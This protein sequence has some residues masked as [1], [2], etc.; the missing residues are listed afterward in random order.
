MAAGTLAANDARVDSAGRFCSE[1][2]DDTVDAGNDSELNERY[3]F[4]VEACVVTEGGLV[5]NWS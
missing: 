1:C 5:S 3:K 2:C 4:G